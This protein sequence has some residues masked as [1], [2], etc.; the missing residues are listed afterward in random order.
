MYNEYME[1]K[2]VYESRLSVWN[3]RFT[4]V[5]VF[6]LISF[7]AA[8]ILIYVGI[9]DNSFAAGISGMIFLLVFIA[10][11]KYHSVINS[12]ILAAQSRIEVLERYQKRFSGEWN[13]FQDDGGVFCQAGDTLSRDIDLLGP[14]SL[15]Q[16]ISV[17]H[18]EEGRKRLSDTLS[19]R[20]VKINDLSR[21]QEAIKELEGKPN[22]IVDFE[23]AANQLTKR[24]STKKLRMLS[25]GDR[26][27]AM[28]GWMKILMLLIPAVNIVLLILMMTHTIHY[29][30]LLLSFLI[31][32][33]ITWLT[34]SASDKVIAPVYRFG[35][36]AADYRALIN[37]IN[38]EDFH[39]A[40]LSEIK[41]EIGGKE[42]ALK[43]LRS[44]ER[45]SQAYHIS[46][47]PLIHMLLSGFLG[48]DYMIAF[49]AG[50][51]GRNYFDK[52]Q[53]CF[54]SIAEIEELASLAVLSC[55]RETHP[56]DVHISDRTG[57]ITCRTMYHPLLKSTEAVANSVNIRRG[58]T[59]ITGSNMSG[60]TTFLRT[61]A[62]NMVL[63]YTGASVCAEQFETDY[64]KIF[65][66]M[67]VMDDI[68]GGI[69]T[70][71]AEIL[72]IKDMA[73]YLKDHDGDI[74]AICLIDEIFKGTNSADRIV[75]AENA[76]RKLSA[77]ES[78]VLVSTHDFELCEL[79]DY[80]GNPV[81]NY[82]FEEYYENDQLL[83][84]YKI[85][86]GRCTTRNAMA[87]LKMAGLSD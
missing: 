84:D 66:S 8:V 34:G 57:T 69:S 78:M 11:I 82:H 19:L 54:E 15:Y 59:V 14:S 71:Y 4:I 62:M 60:K 39:S 26:P 20:D 85:K 55:V 21:R 30:Y 25:G 72:R 53:S 77:G 49:F 42:G 16:F 7:L 79:T 29:G 41:S 36:Y 18:T 51:W 70:F 27:A 86:E 37:C 74:P 3:R 17:A 61:L 2:A 50:R 46:Y 22:F 75:G 33:M 43:G 63:A 9:S 44:L 32:L 13:T 38:N 64:M 24:K 5:S 87:I 67:R 28:P 10:L 6:R 76:I 23:A 35:N 83:F 68:A 73:D 56:A 48:W 65:T 40:V 47:N 12:K 52:M 1:E 81:M 45:I 58:V 31:C 80:Q